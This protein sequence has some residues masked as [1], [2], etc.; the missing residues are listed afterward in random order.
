MSHLLVRTDDNMGTVRTLKYLQAVASGVMVVSESWMQACQRNR[1]NLAKAER[2]EARDEELNG[3]E[4]PRKSREAK[5]RGEAP[6]LKGYEVLIRAEF[7]GLDSNSVMDLLKRAGARPVREM[8]SFS[9]G[10][11]IKLEVNV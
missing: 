6:L 8:N 1:S 4:G 2:W 11:A 10:K 5:V 9:F 7:D 3:S